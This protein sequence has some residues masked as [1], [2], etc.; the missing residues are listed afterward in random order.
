[1][2]SSRKKP[3]AV[4]VAAIIVACLSAPSVALAN[5]SGDWGYDYNLRGMSTMNTPSRDKEDRTSA[6]VH[7]YHMSPYNYMQ[8]KVLLGSG[9]DI[10]NPRYVVK[11]GWT[12]YLEN[13]NIEDYG[14]W[15][16]RI[17]FINGSPNLIATNGVWSPDSV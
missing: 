5:N 13:R 15:N 6:Y 4:I 1:M 2:K 14:A 8:C 3:V 11:Q 7:C 16:A 9:K 12:V 10:G 17:Q